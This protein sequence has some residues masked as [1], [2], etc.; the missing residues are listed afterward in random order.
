ML[1]ITPSRFN[2]HNVW[3]KHRGFFHH[4][5]TSCCGKRQET[6]KAGENTFAWFGT[7]SATGWATYEARKGLRNH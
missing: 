6:E 5:E 2:D 4:A 1:L 7:F 3:T